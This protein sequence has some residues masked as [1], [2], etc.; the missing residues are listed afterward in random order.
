MIIFKSDYI[1]YDFKNLSVREIAPPR[2]SVEILIIHINLLN[3][4]FIVVLLE[5]ITLFDLNS[6]GAYYTKTLQYG[7]VYFV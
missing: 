7:E 4:N 5:V 2:Y 6:T 1:T 3:G